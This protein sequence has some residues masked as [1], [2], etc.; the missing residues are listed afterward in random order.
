MFVYFHFRDKN[1]FLLLTWHLIPSSIIIFHPDFTITRELKKKRGKIKQPF[2]GFKSGLK[3]HHPS[4]LN[5][6]FFA[7]LF[8]SLLFSLD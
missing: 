1:S 6:L 8:I 3:D 2:E 4:Y 7:S 5:K